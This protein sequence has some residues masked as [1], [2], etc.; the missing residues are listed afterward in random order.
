[1]SISGSR[2][3]MSIRVPLPAEA[4]IDAFPARAPDRAAHPID[5]RGHVSATPINGLSWSRSS[6][7]RYPHWLG[8]DRGG[9]NRAASAIAVRSIQRARRMADLTVSCDLKQHDLP[10]WR[11]IM[12]I[13]RIGQSVLSQSRLDCTCRRPVAFCHRPNGEEGRPIEKMKSRYPC[14]QA[15]N[16]PLAP[17]VVLP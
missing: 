10:L 15:D 6:I 5:V 11:R 12:P 4:S 3:A 14:L 16:I 2:S 9:R 8:K 7:Y 13:H 17:I 1:M